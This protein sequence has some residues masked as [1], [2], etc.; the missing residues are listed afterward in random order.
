[1]I[2]NGGVTLWHA[3]G[4]DKKTRMELPP[5]RQYFPQASIQKDIKMSIDIG[6]G[7]RTAD[8]LRVRIPG[9]VDIQIKNGD[10]L[11]V[12]E[13]TAAEPPD[14]AFTV[15]GFADNRKGSAPMWHWKVICG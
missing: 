5:V 15:K 11:I 14:D 2:T 7:F 4:Y 6:A 3:G 8:S 12:G 9:T 10:R 13:S 1:M